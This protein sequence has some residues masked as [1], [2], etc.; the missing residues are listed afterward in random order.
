MGY[1]DGLG[2]YPYMGVDNGTKLVITIQSGYTFDL[3]SFRIT[4]AYWDNQT[5]SFTAINADGSANPGSFG[6]VPVSM[7]G[8]TFSGALLGSLNDVTQVEIFSDQYMTLQDFN[9][10]DVKA[11][12]PVAKVD[13]AHLSTD[14]GNGTGSGAT[15]SDFITNTASQT[16]SGTL[17]ANLGVG[18]KVQV[19]YNNGGTWI[20][21]T[22]YTVG[23]ATW[24]TT[25]TLA[26]SNTF[27]A[28]VS[29]ASASSTAFSHTYTLDT[30]PPATSFSG[31]TLSADTGAS[32]SDFVTKT[33]SQTI[34]ATLSGAPAGT[35]AVWG[36]TD[37]GNSWTNITSK[38]SGTTLTWT[39]ATL[40]AGS[41]AIMFKVTDAAGNDSAL[42]FQNYTL[43]TTA[44]TKSVATASFSNDSGTSQTDF[45]TNT[46]SQTVSGTLSG[47]LLS[48]ETVYVSLDNGATWAAAIATV[49]QNTW[50]LGG[51]TLTASAR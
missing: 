24:S 38:V 30:T 22:N 10:T 46:A 48:G 3:S 23:Q 45:V 44:P 2:L 14:S 37:G 32:G 50:S 15:Y 35:D 13:T 8:A 9:V 26:G 41:D 4:Q 29:N 11:M 12:P 34:N 28:R 5:V 17:S 25:T 16:I 6:V 18:E 1:Y 51:R 47:N 7:D 42:S 49:G 21:A 43:D 40:V 27:L 20:D 33:S 19:S 39:G 31:I 36:S